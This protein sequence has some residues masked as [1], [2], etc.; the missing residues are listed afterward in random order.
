MNDRLFIITI[1]A[2]EYKFVFSKYT[3]N[4]NINKYT[5]AIKVNKIIYNY[6]FRKQIKR[7]IG[8]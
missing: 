1:F 4:C 3:Y 7:T 8:E 6:V 2:F 5:C